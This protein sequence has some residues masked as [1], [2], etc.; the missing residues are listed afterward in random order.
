MH[1]AL[2]AYVQPHMPYLAADAAAVEKHEV[3]RLKP[4][5]LHRAAIFRLL[6]GI[7]RQI[8]SR[9]I[10]KKP[11]EKSRAIGTLAVGAPIAV[12]VPIHS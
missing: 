10:G 11:L 5:A 6:A 7:T 2:I 12:G 4:A 3:A 9:H 8:H 1:H